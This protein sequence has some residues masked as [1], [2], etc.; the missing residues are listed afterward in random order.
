MAG[1]RC[2]EFVTTVLASTPTSCHASGIGSFAA[3]RVERS[4]AWASGSVW[5]RPSSKRTEALST[6]RALLARDRLL[7]WRC[8][9]DLL[10]SF[11]ISQLPQTSLEKLPFRFEF[12]QREGALV[13]GPGFLN[14]ANPAAQIATR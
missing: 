12:D 8:R 7:P 1:G 13:G 11:E 14:P 4:A 5:S 2:F 6:C 3:M 10:V 9:R